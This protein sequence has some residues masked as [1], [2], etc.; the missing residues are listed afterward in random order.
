MTPAWRDGVEIDPDAVVALAAGT[1]TPATPAERLAAN[2]LAVL[3]SLDEY[4]DRA[5]DESLYGEIQSRL[6]EGCA[7]LSYRPMLRPETSYNAYGSADGNDPLSRYDAEQK[8]W[9]LDLIS[10]RVNEVYR[11]RAEG[12]VAVVIACDL[13]CEELPFPRW[14]GFMEIILRRLF[15]ERI[16]MRALAF[17]P[18]S[19]ALLDWELGLPA[20]QE[21]PFAFGQAI[22][23]SRYGNNTTPYLRQLLQFLERGLDDLER[24]TDA[25]VAQFDRRREALAADTRLYHRQQSLLME[26]VMNPS[27]SI[28]AAT[29]ER[30]YD[31]TLV[32][33]RADLKKLVQMGFL[34]LAEV[35]K[36]QVFSPVSHMEDV[37]AAR[38]GRAS[39][40]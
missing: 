7:A 40:A 17:V 23:H 10:T 19:R 30:R 8:S 38:S 11:G 15:F 2:A 25:M 36:K 37:V 28:D 6:D 5:F 39:L 32:T 31:V 35:G 3:R 20:A 4:C 9:C 21:L 14:N 1:R 16:G 34:S 12:I 13:I 24:E 27:G 26:L 33:A 29:Y 18:F 22:L